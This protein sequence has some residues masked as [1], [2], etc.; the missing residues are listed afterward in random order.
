MAGIIIKPIVM[1]TAS[2]NFFRYFYTRTGGY[3]PA[4]PLCSTLYPGDFFQIRNGDIIL[5]G[6]I[7]CDNVIN[8]GEGRLEY[9]IKLNPAGWYFSDGISKPYSGT[10]SGSD[11]ETGDYEFSKQIIAFAK[12]GSFIFHAAQPEV[13]KIANWEELKQQLIIKLTQTLFSFRELYVVTES[14]STTAWSLAI[15]GAENAE[16]EIAGEPNGSGLTDLFSNQNAKVIQSR[17]IDTYMK[18]HGRKPS[19]Y[20]AKKLAVR[21]ETTE[22]FISTLIGRRQQQDE[23][24]SGFFDFED[25][26]YKGYATHACNYSQANVLDMLAANELNPNTALNYFRWADVT[27]DDINKMFTAYV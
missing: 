22:D 23:W 13:V 9:G 8:P 17:D 10:G 25:Y 26:S 14:V 4:K 1:E 19:F 11:E 12:P 24:A 16:I 3:I 20:K 27:L 2:L 7:F 6:N 15:A 5:L 21:D 18:E